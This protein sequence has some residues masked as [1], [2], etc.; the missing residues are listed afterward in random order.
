[1]SDWLR[2][3]LPEFLLGLLERLSSP[4]LLLVLGIVSAVTFIASVV[5]VPFFLT[6]LPE[7]YFSR[8]ERAALGLPEPSNPPWRV[9]LAV[10]KNLLGFTLML[11]GLAMLVLPGQ[12]LLTLVVGLLL[13]DFPGKRRLERWFIGRPSVLRAINSLRR[14]TGRAPLLPRES[15][16]PP[17]PKG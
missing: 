10:L 17:M 12:G 16:L 4:K 7:D 2:G 5:G 15:W 13:A 11:L 14:R 9:A 3:V 1:M 8:R 6:R